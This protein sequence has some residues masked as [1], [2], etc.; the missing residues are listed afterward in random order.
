MST[1]HIE[2]TVNDQPRVA[3]VSGSTT[4][5]QLLRDHYHLTGTK[6]GCGEGDCGACTVILDGLAVK[7]CLV[8][9]VQADGSTVT[10]IEGLSRGGEPHPIQRA[11]VQAGAV[12]CGFCTPGM[13]MAAK[14]LLDTNLSPTEEEVKEALSGNLCRCTGYAKIVSAVK[15]AGALLREGKSG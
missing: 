12:Q 1:H 7:S 4:L 8:L 5:L 10:T 13:V 9:A 6:N 3:S 15:L 2:L 11:F 14:A